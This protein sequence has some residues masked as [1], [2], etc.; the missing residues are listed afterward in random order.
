M[1]VVNFIDNGSDRYL[2]SPTSKCLGRKWDNNAES[3][4]V[5]KPEKE[6]ENSCTMIVTRQGKIIDYINVGKDAFSVTSNLSQYDSVEIG[7]SFSGQNNYV[8][9]SNIEK[10]YFLEAQKPDDFVAVDPEQ[11]ANINAIIGLAFTDIVLKE[12]TTDTYEFKNLAGNTLKEVQIKG[13]GGGSA[14]TEETDPTVPEYVK[15]ISEEDIESWDN[16]ATTDY[17]DQKVAD[18]VNSAPETLDTLGEVAKAIEENADVVDAL[19]SAIGNKAD[20][21]DLTDYVKNTDKA[22]ASKLGLVMA[23]GSGGVAVWGDGLLYTKSAT[24]TQIEAKAS[25]YFPIVPS[26]LDRAVKVGLT[27]NTETLTE[28]EKT[29]A[30]NWLGVPQFTATQLED[31]SYS[32]TIDVEV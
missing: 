12:G 2:I 22:T 31:G 8:K 24:N 21:S 19:N 1:I 6:K 13:A 5:N 18:L 9:N 23:N 29:N 3:I 14:I 10:F 11:S 17:V 4:K 30:Q 27:T 26:N 20:K 25:P 28:E 15:N 7:F 32:L 16:K